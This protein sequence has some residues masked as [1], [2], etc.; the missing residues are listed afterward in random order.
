M[1]SKVLIFKIF[2]KLSCCFNLFF[3]NFIGHIGTRL[4]LS[5]TGWGNAAEWLKIDACLLQK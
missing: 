1:P 3:P 5:M 2:Q 4:N